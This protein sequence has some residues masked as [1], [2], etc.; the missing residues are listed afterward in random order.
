M[1]EY[2]RPGNAA[3]L[4]TFTATYRQHNVVRPWFGANLQCISQHTNKSGHQL[5][6][7]ARYK[8]SINYCIKKNYGIG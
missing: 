3:K 8:V 4:G 7:P 1:N 5:T 6:M 2:S